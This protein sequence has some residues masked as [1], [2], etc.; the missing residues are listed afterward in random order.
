MPKTRNT[1]RT[2]A[3]H[4]PAAPAI[5]N[6]GT[7]S[8]IPLQSYACPCTQPNCWMNAY[9]S[10][11]SPSAL[12]GPRP[13]RANLQSG[14]DFGG[15][16]VTRAAATCG[17]VAVGCV[18]LIYAVVAAMRWPSFYSGGACRRDAQDCRSDWQRYSL[19]KV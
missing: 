7:L 10:A 15:V 18:E 3:S 13:T 17:S 1:R 11:K 14:P 12:S 8:R 2:R 9:S 16:I 5:T 4:T 19:V 6:I